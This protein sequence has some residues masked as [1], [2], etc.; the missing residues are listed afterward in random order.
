MLAMVSA[1]LG[2]TLLPEIAVEQAVR[3]G[4]VHAIS[5]EPPLVRKIYFASHMEEGYLVHSFDDER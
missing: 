3:Q 2:I 1:G 4:N 5:I